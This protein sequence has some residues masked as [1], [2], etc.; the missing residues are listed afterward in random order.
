MT[1][2]TWAPS[3]EAAILVLPL[4][5]LFV[6]FVLAVVMGSP[7]QQEVARGPQLHAAFARR[8]AFAM[9]PRRSSDTPDHRTVDSA[10]MTDQGPST[11][12]T[13]RNATGRAAEARDRLSG[14]VRAHDAW[15]RRDTLNLIA[16][17]N[18]LSPSV[19]GILSSDLEGRYAD[20]P[21]RDLTARR[22]RG[23][24]YIVSIEQEAS[25]LASEVFRAPSVELRPTSGHIAGLAVLMAACRPGDTVLEPGREGGGHREAGRLAVTTLTPLD[26][27]YLPFD[28]LRYNV[29]VPATVRLIE[30]TRPR[31][32]ILGSSTFLFP[33]PVREIADAVH[34]IPG[35]ILAFDASHVMGLLAGG[36]FQ[37]PLLEGADIVFGS[38]HKTFPGPQGGI[39]FSGREDLVAAATGALVPALVTNH[40]PGRMPALGMALAEMLAWGREYADQIV[41]NS[42]ALAHALEANGVPVVS[43]DGVATMSHT[44]LLKVAE[45]G[46][47]DQVAARLEEAGIMT[48]STLLPDVLG[49]EGIR[50]GTQ[51]LTHRGA[52]ED[53]M[54]AIAVTIA[55]A[56]RAS[57]PAAQIAPRVADI[58][59]RLGTVRFTWVAAE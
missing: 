48:T 15:R 9:R 53:L 40:H 51:E 23:N 4:G 34:R 26:V 54:P 30:E 42:Q 37:E 36:R 22:Y 25:R 46:S 29:D 8:R 12:D 39:I 24:R 31:V 41:S 56:V 33:A 3:A 20:Y 1:R 28:G 44:I 38:T 16:S 5:I 49:R 27:R 7:P 11:T 50:I 59:S 18:V 10:A 43:V 52:R 13:V 21:G 14:L 32:V 47:G 19:E 2:R 17:E 55:E 45:F 58:A 35:A 6:L 57:R